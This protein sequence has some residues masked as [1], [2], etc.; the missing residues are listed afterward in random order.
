MQESGPL[1]QIALLP[2]ARLKLAILFARYWVLDVQASH[3]LAGQKQILEGR[4]VL[5]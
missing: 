5:E 3:T 4:I 2:K 1:I